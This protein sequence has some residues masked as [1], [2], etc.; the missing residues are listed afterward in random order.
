MSTTTPAERTASSRSVRARVVGPRL[1]PLDVLILSVWCGLAGGLLEVGARIVCKSLIATNRLYLMSRHFVWLTPL[2]NL[3][4][5][6]G[7]G[8]FLAL[9]AKLWPRSWGWVGPRLIGLLAIMPVL[10][11]MVP[12]VYPVAWAILAMGVALRLSA[13]LERHATGLR[14]RLLLS[15]PA[16]SG[17]VL[18]LA[19]WDFGGEWIAERREASR[20]LPPGDPPNVLLIT[21]DTVRADHLSLYGYGRPTSPVL[22]RL[23]R[24]G[25][26]FDEARAS[27]P[28]TLPSHATMFTG[29][30]HHELSVKWMTP[31]DRKRQTL[32]EYLGEHGYAT[33]GFVANP[34]CSYDS[35]LNRGFT[36]YEDYIL[37]Y[38][39]PFRTAWLVDRVVRT[40]SDLGVFVGRT[41]DV[42]PL[43]PMR[44]SWLSPYLAEWRRKDAGSINLAFMGWLSRRREPDRP[45]FAFLNYYDA[46]APYVLPD[47]AGYRFGLKPQR[48][49]DFIFLMEEWETIDKR[50]LRPVYRGLAGD[51]YDNCVAYLD[52]RL[53]ELL[54]GLRLS[55]VLDRTLVIV[56]ADHGEEMGEHDLFDHGES[57]YRPEIRVPLLI[58]LPA[59]RR[60]TGATRETVSLRDLPATI[61]DLVGLEGGSPFPGRSLAHF[62]R[63]PSPGTGSA[64]AEA[65]ISELPS[66]NPH[67]PNQGRSP[68][69]RGP[70]ISLAEGDFVYIRNTG[71][72]AE[73]LY[74]EREDPGEVQDLSRVEA[75]RP[76]LERLRRRLDRLK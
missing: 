57:L 27:A 63:D 7:L 21:L 39:L 72:G 61:V 13:F 68:A 32:A 30:W 70:L 41:L 38:L 47:G 33:A 67:D 40:I 1:R 52:E 56:T 19:C 17:F 51:S 12:Q 23:A 35:G 14:R 69:Y 3:I 49:A 16:L 66:P 46:H 4:F 5:F 60:C 20:P 37:E 71:D 34:V 53:G 42:G 36:H 2:S 24:W 43:R 50:S 45:F 31:L 65:V 28:W 18:I 6:V 54:E 74:N 26:R 64:D 73:E 15:F 75:L 76:V 58:V 25:V 10:I 11:V 59:G 55:G 22:E 62:L 48:A 8:L 29:R 9:A 44:E